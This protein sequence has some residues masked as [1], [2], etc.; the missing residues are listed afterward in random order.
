LRAL[1]VAEDHGDAILAITDPQYQV[2]ALKRRKSRPKKKEKRYTYSDTPGHGTPAWCSPGFLAAPEVLV[3]EGELNGMICWLVRP[4]LGVMGVA[5]TSGGLH[6]EALKD[7]IIY[8][9]ADG[10]PAGDKARQRWASAAY[11]A[12]AQQ[13][14]TLEP[15]PMDA[16]DLAGKLGRE[17]LRERLS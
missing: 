14:F 16:C 8:I 5:G 3:I 11:N 4:D 2:V 12:S 17:A 6:L 9:Y 15:W 10:D 13:V 1:Q 7:R